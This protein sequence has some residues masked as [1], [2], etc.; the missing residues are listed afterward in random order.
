MAYGMGCLIYGST[1]GVVSTSVAGV[2]SRVRP[3]KPIWNRLLTAK[4][5]F[6]FW[7]SGDTVL[8]R[9]QTEGHYNRFHSTLNIKDRWKLSG[10]MSSNKKDSE[11]C[12]GSLG[13]DVKID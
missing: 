8:E 2:G 12:E 13:A 6:A 4:K 11:L 5:G 3:M 1:A 7:K 10:M 9:T